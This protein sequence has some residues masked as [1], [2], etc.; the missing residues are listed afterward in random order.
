MCY[1]ERLEKFKPDAAICNTT[2]GENNRWRYCSSL[3]GKINGSN[4]VA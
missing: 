1:F 2:D 4:I 3:N